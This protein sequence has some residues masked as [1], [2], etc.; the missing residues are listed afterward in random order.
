MDKKADRVIGDIESA[1]EEALNTSE[2]LKPGIENIPE[3]MESIRVLDPE[4]KWLGP[5]DQTCWEV[6]IFCTPHLRGYIEVMAYHLASTYV[7][8]AIRYLPLSR[9]P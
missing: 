6:Y 5:D 1:I 4:A 3:L 9:L 7:S 2:Y 8:M